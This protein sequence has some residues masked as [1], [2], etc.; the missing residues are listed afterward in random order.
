MRL[1]SLKFQLGGILSNLSN[2]AFNMNLGKV[3]RS[4]K[5]SDY[6]SNCAQ[7]IHEFHRKDSYKHIEP[8]ITPQSLAI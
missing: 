7:M 5:H 3:A 8:S 2:R 6:E 4:Q 1:H